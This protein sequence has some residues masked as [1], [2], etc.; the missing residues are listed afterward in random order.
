MSDDLNDLLVR[1]RACRA[2]EPKLPLGAR[3]VVVA[4]SRARILVAGQA[5]GK[6]VHESGIAWNDASGKRLR[7]WLGLSE[8]RFYDPA[9]VALVP[10]GFCYPGTGPSGDNPPMPECRRLWHDALFAHLPNLRLKIII[11]QYA[12]AYH[13]PERAKGTLTETVAAWR[14]YAPAIYPV[15]HP[16]PRNQMW[17]RRNPWFERDLVPNM[18]AAVLAAL[19]G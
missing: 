14:D 3:P 17:L 18:R 19:C 13:L 9:E 11:G 5:P 10:M 7:D 6:R 2:C 8:E 1:I 4:D 12:H 16:S 15:P